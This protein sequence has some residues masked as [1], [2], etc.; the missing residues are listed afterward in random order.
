MRDVKPELEGILNTIVDGLGALEGRP[1]TRD[2]WTKA[3]GGKLEGGGTT[4]ILEGGELFERGG[5]AMS[6]VRGKA[7]PPSATQR[8]PHLA[9]K[10]FHAVGVSLVM[11][12]R[13]PNVPTAHL[14]V[15]SFR[16]EDNSAWWFGGG[17]DLTPYF[18]EVEDEAHWKSVSRATCERFGGATMYEQLAADCDEYF[19][20]K[21]RQ[22][23]RGLGGIFF[24]D[25]NESHPFGGTFEH[26]WG[27]TRAVGL[28][29]L[30]AYRPI[31]ER[32]R[33]QAYTEADRA[34]Q[35]HRRGRYVEF[36]L[37]WD[38]GTLFGLQS[39]GR[40]E[41]ILMSMPPGATWRYGEPEFDARQRRL[42]ER[43]RVAS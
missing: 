42:M 39:N 15:R 11:H 32:R 24:D 17:F 20:L 5:V 41:S 18:H 40:T 31:V 29:F 43:V 3:P 6:D 30:D 35:A 12:P 33:G 1:F 27:F 38:R 8:N 21:H 4:C 28:A 36:N 19:T 22:E 14:N 9:G 2:V 7:L 37:V 13:N 16:T 10:G 34:W 23:R 25:L 26:C